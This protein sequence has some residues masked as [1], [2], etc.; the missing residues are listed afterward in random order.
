MLPLFR[1][2]A[3]AMTAL[4]LAASAASVDLLVGSYTEG[5]APGLYAYKFDTAS[6]KLDPKPWQ[7]LR[8][9]NPSWLVVSP[10]QSRV[11]AVNENGPGAR[12]AVGRASALTLDAKHVLTLD[13]QVSTLGDH[14]THASLTPDGRYLL[15][16]NYSVNADPGGTLAVLPIDA[17]G[18]L[19]PVTQLSSY[20]ASHVDKDRQLS[21]HIHSVNFAP[22]GKT[23]YVA[24][25]GG[26][27]VYAY[28]Y[29]PGD[30]AERPLQPAAMP[31]LALPPG[32]GPRHLVFDADGQHAYLTLEM[33]GQVATL[34]VAAD[35]ALS[36][37]QV[38]D[39]FEAG[40]KGDNGAGAI[41]LSADGKFLYAVNRGTDNQ[42]AVFAVAADSD[43]SLVQRR[44]TEGRQPREFSIDPSGHFLLVA[45]Q[46]D[47]RIVVIARDPRTGK[48]GKTLQ[49]VEVAAPS[50]LKFLKP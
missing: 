48:L 44:A 20:Q 11:Y 8:L 22:D 41:H 50:D 27:R 43:L 15:V 30:N 35:G 18:Q 32:S 3:L 46:G 21:A 39:L 36:L 34:D 14:P 26:D 17:R 38:H 10:D 7:Q 24:D 49:T 2:T 16:A 28:R 37:R 6:G 45:A 33:T 47:N 12:D 31:F 29:A 42:I 1:L 4:P 23:A 19:Q 40:F 5:D 13:N 9:D 25:L